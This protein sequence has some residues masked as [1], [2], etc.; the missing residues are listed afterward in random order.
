[1]SIGLDVKWLKISNH[2]LRAP[3]VRKGA[4]AKSSTKIT[5][6]S[7]VCSIKQMWAL[8]SAQLRTSF[9]FDSQLEVI[10]FTLFA[11]CSPQWVVTIC[12]Q[13]IIT[14]AVRKSFVM[15]RIVIHIKKIGKIK[16]FIIFLSSKSVSKRTRL[17]LKWFLSDHCLIIFIKVQI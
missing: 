11:H 7:H 13:E 15:N 17:A 4:L 1:M 8:L 12:S 6:R 5:D 3:I 9:Q 10:K 14:V 16:Y 2:A